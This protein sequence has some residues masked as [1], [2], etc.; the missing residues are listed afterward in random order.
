MGENQHLNEN[1]NLIYNLGPFLVDSKHAHNS[2]LIQYDKLNILI[3][4][5][6]IQVFPQQKSAIQKIVDFSQLTYIII[7][8]ITMSS[9]D[10]ILQLIEDGFKGTII[11]NVY[12]ARQI[13]SFNL[14]LK[15]ELIEELKYQLIKQ[16][17]IIFKFIPMV[18]LPYPE[19]F[20]T[21]MPSYFALFSST[22]FSSY[23]DKDT[24]PSIDHLQRSIYAYHKYTM[25]S[26]LYIQPPLKL[27]QK[28]DIHHIYPGMGYL[29]S[30]QIFSA[31][32]D[33]E[34]KLDFYN[35]YQVFTYDAEGEKC[36][37][38]REIINHMLNHLQKY[39]SKIEILNTFIGTSFNLQPDPLMLIKSSVDEYKLWHGFFEHIYVTKGLPWITILEPLVNRYFE[40]YGVAKPNVYM[41]KFIEMTMKAESL[42]KLK[43][44]LEEHIE[45]LNAEIEDTKDQFMRCP[46]THLYNQDFFKHLLKMDLNKPK[47]EGFTKG[48]L[49]IQIDQLTDLNRR[50]GKETG[51]ESLRNLAYQIQQVK[52]PDA[53]LFKQNGPGILI[54][55]E[56]VISQGI[57]DCAVAVRNAINESN[58]F[59]EKISTSIST[60][61]L[62]EINPKLEVDEQIREIFR[63]LDQ[64]NIIAKSKGMGLIIDHKTN[65]PISQEGIVLLVDEDE[66]NLNM[67]NRI[68]KR[69]HFDVKIARGV[70]EALEI[71]DE[72]L[73]DVIISEI[74]LSKIDGFTLKRMLNESKD[75]QKIPFIMVS[76]NKTL[77]NIKRGN[78]LNVN[79]MLEKPIIP[80]ELIGHV[81]R[82]KT[83]VHQ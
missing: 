66:V 51:D 41:S 36:I 44:E 72:V 55:H 70:E 8:N 31:I 37:N 21:Y 78:S 53:L 79:L 77:E 24:Y 68:F 33:F 74:N 47:V 81:K 15:I 61:D 35:N 62:E 59:I 48:F 64:R 80:D 22:L 16:N 11:T 58:L 5:T 69:I 28:L 43:T 83:W 13:V 26:S 52:Q 30:K 40:S 49:L 25:P 23:F 67:L 73:I 32:Y 18:F 42:Q 12:F 65:L 27:L 56:K 75:H 19:M 45:Q 76:H 63:L 50:Y 6:P 1:V 54:Y 71:I 4:L 9:M 60:V 20:M 39:F 29:I 7:Q 10:V 3:D 57:E 38:Y 2:Y 14:P 34:Q 46:I 17:Q 82:Y